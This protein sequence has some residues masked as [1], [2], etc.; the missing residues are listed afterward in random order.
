MTIAVNAAWTESHETFHAFEPG[1]QLFP[2]M[3]EQK[4]MKEA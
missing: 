2:L 1:N 4:G 3:A